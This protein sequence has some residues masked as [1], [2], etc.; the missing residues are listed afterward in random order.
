MFM[1]KDKTMDSK[2]NLNSALS[3]YE[4][5]LQK[6]YSKTSRNELEE[7]DIRMINSNIECEARFYNIDRNKFE[8]VYRK[9][10]AYGFKKSDENYQLKIMH[11]MDKSSSKIRCELNDLTQIREFCKSNVLPEKTNYV[12]KE[13]FE[14][15]PTYYDNRDFNFRLAIQKEFSLETNDPIVNDIILNWNSFDK[16]FRYMNRIEMTHPDFPSI[17]VDMSIVKSCVDERNQLLRENEFSSSKLFEQPETYEIEIELY[18]NEYI[19]KNLTTVLKTIPRIIKYVT[20]GIQNSDFP[21][22]YRIQRQILNEYNKLIHKTEEE[23]KY[24]NNMLFIGPSSMTLQKKNLSDDVENA[25]PCIMND[26]CVTDKADGERKLCFIAKTGRIYFI[27]IN[28]Q[29]E[30]TGAFT[31]ES[32]LLGSLIDGELI[33]KDTTGKSIK[34]YA[35]FDLYFQENK[36]YRADAFYKPGPEPTR[37]TRLMKLIKSLNNNVN[38][39][40]EA[41]KVSF[42]FKK[43]VMPSS[44]KNIMK[45]S[46]EVFTRVSTGIL[47]YETDGLIFTSMSLG[48]GMEKPGDVPPDKKY[49]WKHSFKWKPPE[50]NTIDFLVETKKAKDGKDE[51]KNIPSEKSGLIDSYKILNL[52]VGHDPRQGMINPQKMLFN[53]ELPSTKMN[54]ASNTYQKILFMPTNPYDSQAHICYIPLVRDTNGDLKMMTEEGETFE[55]DTIVEFR[56]EMKDNKLFNWIP[57]RVRHDKTND[58]RTTNRNF[59]NNYNTANTVWNSIHNPITTEMIT[60]ENLKISLSDINDESVYYNRKQQGK[61]VESL[62]VNLRNFHNW[63]VKSLLYESVIKP[64]N[65]VIDYAVGQ[66]G[67]I[68]K[69]LK[70][71]PKFVLGI[72]IARDNIHNNVSGVCARY[73]KLKSE[74]KHI[75]NGLFIQGNSSKL[76]MREEFADSEDK[77]E[78]ETSKFVIQQIFSTKAKSDIHGTYLSSMYGVAKNR[79]DVGSIQFAMHYMF[80]DIVSMHSFIKNVAD[81]VR[82]GGYFIGTCFDGEI[83]FNKLKN[84]DVGDT[85]YIYKKT[86]ENSDEENAQN[87]K[88]IWSVTKK[89]NNPEFNN[90]ESSLGMTI[91]VFQETINKE[92][93]EYL[94]NFIYFINCMKHYGFVPV[95]KIPGMEDLPGIGNFK[96]IYDYIKK[97]DPNSITMSEEEMEISFLN[98]YFIF[99]KKDNILNT[100]DIFKRFVEGSEDDTTLNQIGKP[101]KLNKHIILK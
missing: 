7:R 83:L 61:F 32:E 30:Y 2:K 38:Y 81:T 35:A 94:V 53:G 40:S 43:F 67:D 55:D 18:N 39:E 22:S 76:I 93:D 52:Y 47:K 97:N 66:G 21:I 62:T 5:L 101:V 23:L 24:V 78:Q 100:D 17:K 80:K 77:E 10:L 64:G 49:T 58:Y 41:D 27:D 68:N 65:L 87:K 1:S 88:K 28:M 86:V 69:W 75:F 3:I 60:D 8:N 34:I 92:F 42:E 72:D 71:R 36:N 11:Y 20:C 15:Y 50:F 31:N 33:T 84:F 26:F 63:N 91:S 9:L 95:Q 46:A 45:C 54:Y 44:E 79:F 90:D 57:L 70:T 48:V 51:I 85:Y 89:Y 4:S 82:L 6:K 73:L 13:R 96:L 99:K 74:R 59:G 12:L 56:Y 29:V 19:H 14:E 98:K 16:S 25:E 37:Y